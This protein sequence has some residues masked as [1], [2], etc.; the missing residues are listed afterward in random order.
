M[1]TTTVPWCLCGQY[2]KEMNISRQ[3]QDAYAINS[4]KT[5]S[6]G[7]GCRKIQ[8]EVIGVEVAGKKGDVTLI[9]ED[10]EYKNVNFEKYPD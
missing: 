7:M 2:S 9:G 4:Y 10:E 5:F 1:S 6:S 8:D 3:D